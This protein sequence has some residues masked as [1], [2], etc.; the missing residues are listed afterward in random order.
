M[1][2]FHCQVRLRLTQTLTLTRVGFEGTLEI[3]NGAASALTNI[4]VELQFFPFG[5]RNEAAQVN[6]LFV[7]GAPSPTFAGGVHGHGRIEAHS[8]SMSVWLFLP[9]EE[10]CEF[11]LW[12]RW[13]KKYFHYYCSVRPLRNRGLVPNLVWTPPGR[14]YMHCEPSQVTVS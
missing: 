8:S 9:L 6:S 12:T 13:R 10:V 5:E 14:D 11:I 2:L 7:V 3:D 4:S 1:F